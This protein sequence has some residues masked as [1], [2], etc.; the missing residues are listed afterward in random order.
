MA[1]LDPSRHNFA[2][3]SSFKGRVGVALAPGAFAA[4]AAASFNRPLQ[5][6][7]APLFAIGGFGAA[8]IIMA[9]FLDSEPK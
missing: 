7:A 5:F 8:A 3:L 2:F 4:A 6:D 1:V 9:L